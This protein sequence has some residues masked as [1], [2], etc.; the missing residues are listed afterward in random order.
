MRWI[1]ELEQ[2]LSSVIKGKK[3]AIRL[4]VVALLAKGH[5]LIE[6]VPGVGKTT[7]ALTLAKAT[8]CSFHRIQ[9]T[10]DLL[11]SDI[12]GVHIYNQEKR[13]FEFNPGPIFA[14]IVLADEINRTNPKTQ[15]ALLEAMNERK[16]SID[17]NTYKLPVPFMVIATQNPL[18]YHGTF[19][20]PE[21]QLDRFMLHMRIGY[22]NYEDEKKALM[23]MKDF[24][25]V[26]G[27]KP[28]VSRQQILDAQA[29]AERVHMDESIYDYL[30]QIVTATRRHEKIR[31]G[32]S[33]RGAQFFVRAAR[34]HAFVNGRDYVVP[35]DIKT[36]A[37]NVLA[38]RIIL[39]SRTYIRDAEEVIRSIV[40]R[41]PVPV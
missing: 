12:L 6:D 41:V 15:S 3:E 18:E 33:T 20:L 9:F 35:D 32:V 36:V 7:L 11:P 21:S 27:I 17:R 24:E 29:M 8:D 13:Q 5:L 1:E 23:E 38:H 31:L 26:E 25:T 14:N 37:P 39:K 10:S 16:V 2:I 34:A 30:L 19:P 28:V 40:E 4:A 22:P